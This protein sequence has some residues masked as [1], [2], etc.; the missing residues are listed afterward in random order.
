MI[1]T[2]TPSWSAGAYHA[3]SLPSRFSY[4]AMIYSGGSAGQYNGWFALGDATMVTAW[5]GGVAFHP[6][7]YICSD[8]GGSW[9]HLM[10]YTPG[11]WYKVKVYMDLIPRTFDVYINGI[12]TGS[13]IPIGY[14]GTPTGIILESGNADVQV[15]FDDV[16]VYTGPTVATNDATSIMATTAILHGNLTSNDGVTTTV[17]IFSGTEDGVW[18]RS[19]NLSVSAVGPFSLGVT[20]LTPGTPYFY[21]CYA[22]NAAGGN[23]ATTSASFTT[24]QPLGLWRNYWA[25]PGKDWHWFSSGGP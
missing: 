24:Q 5:Y 23:W 2:G 12:L 25:G 6:D 17:A 11:E 7:G 13:N 1:L 9:T 3:V 21:R 8:T 10:P 16:R 20:G 15:W 4:E 14:A 18:S 22:E 19:D